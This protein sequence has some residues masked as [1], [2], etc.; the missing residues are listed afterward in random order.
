M[1]LVRRL[2]SVL[3]A[4]PVLGFVALLVVLFACAYGAGA[5][6]GPVAPGMRPGGQA[7]GAPQQP[8]DGGGMDGMSGMGGMG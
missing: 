4:K 5:A 8:A 2:S 3:P 1:S 7:P 6:A